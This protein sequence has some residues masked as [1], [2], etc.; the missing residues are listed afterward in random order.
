MNG[1]RKVI[2]FKTDYISRD[3]KLVTIADVKEFVNI[4]SRYSDLT[5]KQNR[6]IVSASSLMGMFSLD[7]SNPVKLCFDKD[8]VQAIELDFN[9]WLVNTI[10]NN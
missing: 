8:I 3:I 9:R 4:A 2:D 5:V 1:G 7:L 10:E 6:F